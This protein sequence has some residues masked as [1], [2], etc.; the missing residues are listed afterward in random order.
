MGLFELLPPSA[1]TLAR[2]SGDGAPE[3]VPNSSTNAPAD[4][5]SSASKA[6]LVCG[7]ALLRR[8]NFYG[9]PY[10]IQ[11]GEVA[12]SK[13]R[14]PCVDRPPAFSAR[15]SQGTVL[16][17]VYQL[18]CNLCQRNVAAP[19]KEL[20]SLAQ[21]VLHPHPT[22]EKRSGW[23]TEHEVDSQRPQGSWRAPW[24]TSA[25]RSCSPWRGH[26]QYAADARASQRHQISCGTRHVSAFARTSLCRK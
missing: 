17:K 21:H 14:I 20:R 13:S 10:E 2:D 19:H 11:P 7:V 23:S 5:Y 12:V 26:Y 25:S 18:F 6:G 15:W 9:S 1:S 8:Y 4:T 22:A 24:I 16:D 3:S